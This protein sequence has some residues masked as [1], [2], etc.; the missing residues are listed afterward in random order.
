MKWKIFYALVICS[1][2]FSRVLL[3]DDEKSDQETK[4]PTL[5]IAS[6]NIDA[7]DLKDIQKIVEGITKLNPQILCL[8]EVDVLTKR[9]RENFVDVRQTLLELLTKTFGSISYHYAKEFQELVEI[10]KAEAEKADGDYNVSEHVKDTIATGQMTLIREPIT[11]TKPYDTAQSLTFKKQYWLWTHLNTLK[12]LS[13]KIRDKGLEARE[14]G[15][16]VLLSTIHH[17]EFGD[18]YIINLHLESKKEDREIRMK[19]LEELFSSKL[20][21]DIGDQ[22]II[23]AGDFNEHQNGLNPYITET[24]GF[25]NPFS[26]SKIPTYPHADKSGDRIDFIY[27]KNFDENLIIRPTVYGEENGGHGKCTIEGSDHCPISI[28]IIIP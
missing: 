12:W 20:F 6:W 9:K 18:I 3:A 4:K 7:I 8:Q 16:V 5:T 24:F 10:W 1:M 22:K 26:E 17:P 2:F 15:R 27:L 23:L 11:F 14:G 13:Y 25:R 28:D 21:K 19:Q